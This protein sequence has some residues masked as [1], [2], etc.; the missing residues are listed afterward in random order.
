MPQAIAY[1]ASWAASAVFAASGGTALW[2]ASA[3]LANSIYWATYAA[4]YIATTAAIGAAATSVQ[5]NLSRQKA[6]GGL[7]KLTLDPSAQR[8]LIV[9]RRMT[10]GI[11]VDWFVGPPNNTKLYMPIYLSEGPCGQI[12][13]VFDNGRQVFNTPLVHGVRTEIPAYR[14][15]EPRLWLTYYDGRVGQTANPALVALGQ[16]WTSANKMVGCAYVVVEAWWD[17]DNMRSPP[18]LTFEMDGAKLYDRRLDSTAGG[19]GSHRLNDPSTWAA[20]HAEGANPAVALDHFMLGRF[21]GS[22]RVFGV[23]LDSDDVPYDRFAAQANICDEN[24]NLKAGGTQK[25]YRSNGFIMAGDEFAFTITRLCTAMS[26][27]PADFGGR[28]GVVGIEARTPVMTI[29][30]DDLIDDAVEN[31]VPKKSFSELYGAVEGRY[32]NPDALYQPADFPRVTD[33]A[34]AVQDNG[35]ARTLTLELDMESNIERA[36]RLALLAAKA[37]RRQATLSGTYP[38]WAVEL[39]RGDWFTRTGRAGSRFGEAGKVFEVIE[40]SLDPKTF[41]VTIMAQEVDPADSAWNEAAAAD[42]PAAA[43]S[44][45]ASLSAM[46]V[47]AIVV[48]AIS[49]VGTASSIPALKVAFTAAVDPR[50]KW[51][52]I[53][54]EN[55]DGTTPKTTKQIAIPSNANHVVFQEGIV[56][57][58]QYAVSAKFLSDTLISDWC[59]ASLIF[60]SGTYAVG[61]ASSVPWSGV[62]GSGKPENNADVTGTHNA[63]TFTGQGSLSLLNNVTSQYLAAGV[64]RNALADTEFRYTSTQWR[65]SSQSGTTAGAVNVSPLG[66]RRF[67]V[68]GAGVTVGHYVQADSFPQ[69]APLQVTAGEY[70]EASAYV[71]GANTSQTLLFIQCY[72]AAGASSGVI[73][74]GGTAQDTSPTAGNGEMTTFERLYCFGV[75]PAGTVRAMVGVR[76]LASTAAPVLNVTK[77]FLAKSHQGQTQPTPYNPGLD[78]EPG[79]NVTETRNAATFTGQGALSLLNT[80]GAAQIGVAAVTASK[81]VAGDDSNMLLDDF[82]DLSAWGASGSAWT[83]STGDATQRAVMG[84]LRIAKPAV[85]NGT[86]SQASTSLSP[87]TALRVGVEPLK[88]VRFFMRTLVDAGYTGQLRFRV[89][90]YGYDGVQVG[91]T[92]SVIGTSYLTVAAASQTMQDLATTLVAPAGAATVIIQPFAAYPTA[93][94]A[95]GQGYFSHPRVYKQAQLGA[96]VMLEDGVTLAT[97]ALLQTSLGNAATFTGQGGLSLLNTVTGAYLAAGVGANAC[98]DTG[99]RFASQYWTHR[100]NTTGLTSTYAFG[101]EGGLLRAHWSI[102]GTPTTGTVFN[103]AQGGGGGAYSHLLPVN[104]AERIEVS[105]YFASSG[106]QHCKI[107]INELD[108]SGTLVASTSLAASGSASGGGS[109]ST[110]S[111]AASF[112]TCGSTTRFVALEFQA[113]ANGAANPWAKATCP[114]LRRAT[115]GQT[116]F[117]PFAPGIEA[118]LGADVT[119]TNNAATITGQGTQATANSQRGASYVGTPTDWS[120]WADTSTSKLKLWV[121]GAWVVVAS[122][123]V[124]P[125]SAIYGPTTLTSATYVMMASVTMPAEMPSGAKLRFT[126]GVTEASSASGTTTVDWRIQDTTGGTTVASGTFQ[127]NLAG[128]VSANTS[129]T[130]MSTQLFAAAGAGPRT[131]E[132]QM[133]KGTQNLTSIDGILICERVG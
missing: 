129:L 48:S 122:L 64:G 84:A 94:N 21:L 98:V 47:P 110:Y 78:G 111:R 6:E 19:S 95:A 58:D 50:V 100:Y 7:I 12:T 88:S 55:T 8:R 56:D 15:S 59:I 101:L 41:R 117:T 13:R 82:A 18:T 36:Q 74:Y 31:Y 86:T 23:G 26:A 76:A 35:E 130:S 42:A 61:A 96:G 126:P 79:G 105:A 80:V 39:E 38:T 104:G 4:T 87:I 2:A 123:V 10:G 29:D 103:L 89:A 30:D 116:E 37:Q 54:V 90:W 81:M 120:W 131:Y 45:T 66:V 69:L 114:L 102:T 52:Y 68:T 9:G 53:E 25:R 24:V 118:Q 32:Q 11:L 17:S 107:A 128:V 16:G 40:R 60:S 62:T 5:K 72:D 27:R 73:G 92:V 33:P 99:F 67:S 85:G 77:P 63:A 65:T 91:S 43:T 51:L 1:V 113:T 75:A 83:F 121:A 109:L 106:L 125:Q 132:F 3:T 97:N 28:F 133:K 71:G 44:G 57:G 34:W 124:E 108:A 22:Q 14:S 20:S 46:E 112:H 115:A 127:C 93:I 70:L 119:G 49:L